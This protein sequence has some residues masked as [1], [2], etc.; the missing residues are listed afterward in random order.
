MN[1]I[2]TLI[3]RIEEYR[4]TNKQPCKNYATKE[5]AEKALDAASKRAGEYF[6]SDKQPARY[7]VFFVP[8]WNRWV[9]AL[10]YSE[11]FRRKTCMGGYVGAIAGFFT[12]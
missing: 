6:D 5:A 8:A 9:G 3:A 2:D 12:Y 4:T 1:I 10:D 7:V 11:M